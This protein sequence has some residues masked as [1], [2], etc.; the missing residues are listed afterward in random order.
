MKRSKRLIPVVELAAKETKAILA[1][2]GKANHAWLAEKKQLDDL[3]QYREEY[4]AKFR[5][6]DTRVMSAQKVL[7]LRGFLSQIDQAINAQHQQVAQR[8]KEL[9]HQRQCWKQSRIKERAVQTLVARYQY[10]ERRI[11]EKKEQRAQDEHNTV[12]WNRK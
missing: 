3:Y 11:E 10:E 7:S 2:V 4:L 12:Q 8:L 9:E 1:E 5:S 6:A